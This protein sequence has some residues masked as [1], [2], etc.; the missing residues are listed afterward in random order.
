MGKMP[1]IEFNVVLTGKEM[2]H[3]I[4]VLRHRGSPTSVTIHD[5]LTDTINDINNVR[6]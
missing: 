4:L 5:K 3:L 6:E 2:T 1:D